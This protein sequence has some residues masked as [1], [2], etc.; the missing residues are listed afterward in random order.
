MC[1]ILSRLLL[2]V[3]KS[4]FLCVLCVN[5]YF[6]RYFSHFL[7][8]YIDVCFFVDFFI[9]QLFPSLL[10]FKKSILKIA[11]Y[12]CFVKKNFISMRFIPNGFPYIFFTEKCWWRFLV[13]FF[14]YNID[15]LTIF[16]FIV[17]YLSYTFN[18][19]TSWERKMLSVLICSR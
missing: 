17:L 4:L 6:M 2:C 5:I 19:D 15:F 1:H 9:T 13:I 7:L 10:F 11:I 8:L 14:T 12:F 16:Y 18:T 3:V